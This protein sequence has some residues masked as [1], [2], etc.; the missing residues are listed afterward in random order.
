MSHIA[1]TLL[2]HPYS[3]Q[4]ACNSVSIRLLL[5]ESVE[6]CEAGHSQLLQPIQLRHA[7]LPS[8]S[9][10]NRS[11]ANSSC[12]PPPPQN[13]PAYRSPGWGLGRQRPPA[14]TAPPGR[15]AH[16]RSAPPEPV[17]PPRARARPAPFRRLCALTPAA[18]APEPTPAPC[19]P[20][21][22]GCAGPSGPLLLR[23]WRYR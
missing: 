7:I 4:A 23:P 13:P 6:S 14:A 9:E 3:Q 8:G 22:R 20:H 1:Q 19:A 15:S 18:P 16:C 21:C 5:S 12:F 10:T 2:A 17:T 11:H